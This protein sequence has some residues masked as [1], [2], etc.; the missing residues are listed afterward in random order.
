MR[1]PIR[2]VDRGAGVSSFLHVP[3]SDRDAVCFG[4][5]TYQIIDYLYV[6]IQNPFLT[7]DEIGHSRIGRSEDDVSSAF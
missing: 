1:V 3:T 4:T 2:G 5:Q 6:T 7:E